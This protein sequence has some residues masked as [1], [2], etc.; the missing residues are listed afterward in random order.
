M[1][2]IRGTLLAVEIMRKDH[3]GKGGV[4]INIASVSGITDLLP[5]DLLQD[6][7]DKSISVS[8]CCVLDKDTLSVA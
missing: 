6:N 2:T 5:S 1:G 4:V 8:L 3:G 7:E